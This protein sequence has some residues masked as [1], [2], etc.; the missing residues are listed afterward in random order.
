M[1]NCA[2]VKEWYADQLVISTLGCS[3]DSRYI[4]CTAIVS[5]VAEKLYVH[6]EHTLGE[7]IIQHTLTFIV[8]YVGYFESGFRK[9]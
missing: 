1:W 4:D 7:V 8:K 3:N 2:I 6:T 5:L 9:E